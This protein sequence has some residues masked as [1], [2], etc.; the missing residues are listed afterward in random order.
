[1]SAVLCAGGEAEVG[2]SVVEAVV[3]NMVDEQAGGVV[4]YLAVHVNIFGLSFFV[5][6][7]VSLGVKSGGE[8]CGVPII[9]Y[10]ARVIFGVND[11]EFA[12]REGY[13]A[14]GVAEAN[15][16]IQEQDKD[17]RL[18]EPVRDFDNNFSH[19]F[20]RIYTVID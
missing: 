2:L 5:A 7:G 13:A 6:R 3:V 14:K 16:P 1:M 20:S 17:S 10:Q 12:S 15:P 9:L 18:F 19:G 4:H 8:F 11:G